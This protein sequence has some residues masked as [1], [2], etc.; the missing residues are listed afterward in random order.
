MGLN[1]SDGYNVNEHACYST[2]GVPHEHRQLGNADTGSLFHLYVFAIVQSFLAHGTACRKTKAT[3]DNGV[4]LFSWM[5][6]YILAALVLYMPRLRTRQ[7]EVIKN[8]RSWPRTN[9][10]ASPLN[11][12]LPM[13]PRSWGEV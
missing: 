5:L 7:T 1:L 10:G 3:G 4:S 8:R 11:A 9:F 13:S 2:S 6:L 12:A